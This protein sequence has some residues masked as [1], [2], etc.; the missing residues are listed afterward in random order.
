MSRFLSLLVLA[1]L[2]AS[3]W[4]AAGCS[5]DTAQEKFCNQLEEVSDPQVAT[6]VSETAEGLRQLLEI[7]PLEVRDSIRVMLDTFEEFIRTPDRQAAQDQLV[8]RAAEL[9]D[10][11]AKLEAYAV[12]ECGLN[13]ERIL[14]PNAPPA[15]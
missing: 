11:A 8:E 9:N 12:R 1:V 5:S 4:L 14:L 10:S 6:S 3:V 15:V 7:A 2:S 13:L